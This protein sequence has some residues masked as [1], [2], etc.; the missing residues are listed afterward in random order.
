MPQAVVPIDER[1]PPP[2]WRNLSFQ[3]MWLSTAA[4]GFGDRMIELVALPMLGVLGD[5]AQAASITAAI[6]FW[7]FLPWLFI[8]PFGGWLADTLPR[9]W[10][11]L[12]CDEG[13]AAL[14][15]LAAFMVPAG[16]AASQIPPTEN[17]KVYAILFG[18]G[19][20]A[21]IFSP[22]RNAL[23]PQIVPARQL[24][25]ANS[26]ILGIGVIASLIG[27]LLG[28]WLLK[29]YSVR[30]GIIVA[31]LC[32]AVT[33]LFWAFLRPAPRTG[34]D[35]ERDLSEWTRFV[36]A[37]TYIRTH[38]P[39][40]RLILLNAL[41]WSVAMVVASAIAALCKQ[42]YGITTDF[43]W[44]F[45]IMSAM[46]GVGMLLAAAFVTWINVRREADTVV[47]AVVFVTG[48]V[49]IVL[50]LNRS[51]P[52]ALVLAT[53]VGFG[54]G[55]VM[56]MI[57]TQIQLITPNFIL[58]R[59][60]GVR[61]VL[62]NVIAVAVNF[63]VWQYSADSTLIVMLYPLALLLMGIAI[64][65]L[66]RHLVGGPMP[67]GL[68]NLIWRSLRVYT[69]V[70][71]RLRWIGR[72]HVPHAGP[73]ILAPNHTAG[74]DPF[75][76]QAA[77]PRLVCWLM[78]TEY[79]LRIAWWLW[80]TCQPI[81]LDRDSSDM[82]KIRQ[83]VGRLRQDAVV[84]IFPE[85]E[86]QRTKR[87]LMPFQPGLAVIAKRSNAVIVPVWIDGTPKWHNMIWHFLIPSRCTIVFGEPYKP[88]PH[89]DNEAIMADLRRRML[90]LRD[91][92]PGRRDTEP[93]APV[94][95]AAP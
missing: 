50:G 89:G 4:S 86:L 34:L 18:V 92:L 49:L 30:N 28:G 74:L 33:G 56:I 11:M 27:Y 24:N 60:G 55:V 35:V 69:A 37:I 90:A 84:G 41:L 73:V 12:G 5:S 71:Y 57:A 85:G 6:Y 91:A 10:V 17:W 8:S 83:I 80:D 54:G 77:L 72:D 82:N 45:A 70:W 15:L 93:T 2:L 78:L 42:R 79:R 48:L 40:L 39:V 25:P 44:W 88:D 58:G 46:L 20:L 21:A 47:L 3:L 62:S 64:Y 76:L 68:G 1:R 13:R 94:A 87:Q 63:A 26:M 95:A 53:L 59:V 52:V 43:M 61:E 36:R 9:K 29:E 67:S 7:F 23:I 51:Y 66:V 75:L 81:A 65:G 38:R 19:A 31:L 22:T 32:Y 16:L 14:L